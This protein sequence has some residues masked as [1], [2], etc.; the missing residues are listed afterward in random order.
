MIST[1]ERAIGKYVYFVT[2]LG[3]KK[4]RQVLARL[5]KMIGPALGELM[6]SVEGKDS[7]NIGDAGPAIALLCAQVSDADLEYLCETFSEGTQVKMPDGK[8][9]PLNT[10]AQELIFGGHIEECFK[11][12]AFCLEANYAGFFGELKGLVGPSQQVADQA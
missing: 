12:L 2:Q 11:W 4:S 3:F 6:A 1:S 10:D 9:V 5:T 7:F 8:R